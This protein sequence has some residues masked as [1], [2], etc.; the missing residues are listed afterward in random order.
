[1]PEKSLIEFARES[2][3]PYQRIYLKVWEGRVKARKINGRWLI[4]QAEADRFLAE[5]KSRLGGEK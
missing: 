1:M 2:G 5:R 4:D 3:I